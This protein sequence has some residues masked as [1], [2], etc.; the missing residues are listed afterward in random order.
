MNVFQKRPV[1]VG[2]MVLAIIT[3]ILLGQ[4]R[5][6]NDTSEASTAIVGSYT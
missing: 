6:P 5:K 3:G 1:A 4:V 2:I